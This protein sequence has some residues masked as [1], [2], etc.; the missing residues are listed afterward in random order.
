MADGV[1]FHGRS[2]NSSDLPSYRRPRQKFIFAVQESPAYTDQHWEDWDGFFNLSMTYKS[3][4]DI[5]YPYGETTEGQQ[6]GN[7][8]D[9]SERYG[10]YFVCVF[11]QT[12]RSRLLIYTKFTYKD[13]EQ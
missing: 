11:L 7:V 13:G 1:L 5:Y 4:A 9:F 12:K 10:C 3:D 8:L 6:D 2:M